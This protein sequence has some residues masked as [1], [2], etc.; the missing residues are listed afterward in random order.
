MKIPKAKSSFGL[1]N[2]LGLIF[3]LGGIILILSLIGFNLPVDLK[4]INIALQYVAAVGSI[5]GG[6]SMLFKKRETTQQIQLK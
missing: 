6:V 3:I 2:I 1:G 5:L 4:G